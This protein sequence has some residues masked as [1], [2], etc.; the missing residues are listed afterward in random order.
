MKTLGKVRR[1]FTFSE[2]REAGT[3]KPCLHEGRRTAII[4]CPF[5]RGKL[6]LNPHKVDQDG[7]VS[8]SVV[9]RPPC[10]FHE[11]ITL[12]DWL[13]LPSASL[14]KGEENES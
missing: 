7:D 2:N 8:P 12:K 1:I 11:F 5:C 10:S 14:L 6:V 4:I 9:C 3:Y 13:N